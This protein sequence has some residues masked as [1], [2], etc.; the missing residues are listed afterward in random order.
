MEVPL[1]S[2]Y[3]S[4]ASSSGSSSPLTHPG[5]SSST[6]HDGSNYYNGTYALSSEHG[7]D[8][9]EADNYLRK[10]HN[11]PCHVHVHLNSLPDP[12]PGVRP[13]QTIVALMLLA[14]W[15]S[16]S[17]QLSCNEICDAI[18]GRFKYYRDRNE[19]NAPWKVG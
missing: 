3:H 15:G 18:A 7:I 4:S 5:T 10:A 13:P 11:L 2:G 1:Y 17:K 6:S 12:P 16:P 8:P 19:P 9:V 14:I